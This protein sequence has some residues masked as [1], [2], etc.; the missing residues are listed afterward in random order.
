MLSF[1]LFTI[2]YVLHNAMKWSSIESDQHTLDETILL[3]CELSN[4]RVFLEDRLLLASC[5]LDLLI[6]TLLIIEN[7]M[8]LIG[9]VE[10]KTNLCH[11]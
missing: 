8:L 1:Y 5:V 3:V 6:V 4:T 2:D 7:R 10:E 9:L 11:V